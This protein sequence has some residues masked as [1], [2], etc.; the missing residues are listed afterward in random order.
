MSLVTMKK[1]LDD[2]NA[3][4]YAVPAFDV[5]NYEMVRYVTEA[6]NECNSPLIL[7][8]LTEDIKDNGLAYIMA[9]CKIAAEDSGVPVAIHLDHATDFNL[10]RKVIDAGGT[11][12]M[13][14][15]SKESFERN[16]AVTKQVSDYAHK[17]GVSVE[18]ELGHVTTSTSGNNNLDESGNEIGL[19]IDSPDDFLTKANEVVRFVDETNIDALAV[20]IGTAHGVYKRKPKINFERLK[21]I[22]AVSTVPLVLHGGS[23]TPDDDIKRCVELGINKI[24]IYSEILNAFNSQLKNTLNALDNLSSWHSVV[25]DEACKTIKDVVKEKI[26]LCGSDGKGLLKKQVESTRSKLK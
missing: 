4:G 23:G 10:I 18:A 11:S 16:V 7:M 8:I 17:Y 13:I 24:N 12:V 9:M 19:D 2:A 15:A 14:D 26:Y 3:G 20:A 21:Q 25:F 5:S 6:A 22:K 1:V